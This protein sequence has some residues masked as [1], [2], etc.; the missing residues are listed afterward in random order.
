MMCAFGGWPRGR[1]RTIERS[2]DSVRRH[3][4]ALGQ[5]F[6]QALALCQARA[7]SG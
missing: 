3:L 2:H 4:A 6:V 1:P 7:S 5:L